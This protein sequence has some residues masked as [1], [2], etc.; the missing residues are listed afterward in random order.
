MKIFSAV[1]CEFFLENFF[2]RQ[3]RGTLPPAPFTAAVF[4]LGGNHLPRRPSFCSNL[5]FLA[6]CRRRRA[7]HTTSGKR[8]TRSNNSRSLSLVSYHPSTQ[9]GEG[10]AV[11]LS[12]GE[13]KAR[14]C[15]SKAEATPLPMAADQS[16]EAVETNVPPIIAKPT[17]RAKIIKTTTYPSY[18]VPTNQAVL[19]CCGM[20]KKKAAIAANVKARPGMRVIE[21]LSP[22]ETIQHYSIDPV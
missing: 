10:H 5:L 18:S 16:Y 22:V 21:R 11:R 14:S 17:P 20:E 13:V 6:G 12:V 7:A 4:V 8:S 15:V 2:E 1:R 19:P 3:H 9:E